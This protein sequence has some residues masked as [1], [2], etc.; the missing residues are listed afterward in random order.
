MTPHEKVLHGKT[1]TATR[2][3][4]KTAQSMQENAQAPPWYRRHLFPKGERL[5]VGGRTVE[6]G[7]IVTPGIAGVLLA[8]FLSALGYGYTSNRTDSRETRDAIIRMEAVLNERT[9]TFKNQQDEMQR[10]LDD[11]VKLAQLQRENQ[12]E[13]IR[14]LQEQVK[15]RK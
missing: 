2:N 8:A 7:W 13:K 5:T 6:R 10:K 1:W 12:N 9:T 15:R 14:E 3:G 4:H 11:E